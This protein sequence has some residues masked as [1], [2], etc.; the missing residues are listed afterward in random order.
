MVGYGTKAKVTTSFSPLA[1]LFFFQVLK[2][3]KISHF[4]KFACVF[5]STEL[6]LCQSISYLSFRVS[7]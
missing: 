2:R 3:I 1:T 6:A 7:G 5:L 4:R